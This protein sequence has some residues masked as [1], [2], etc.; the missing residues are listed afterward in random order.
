MANPSYLPRTFQANTD[1]LFDRVIRPVLSSLPIHAELQSGVTGDLNVFLDRCAAQVDNYTAN[2]AAKAFSLT[3]A[4]LFERQLRIWG[5]EMGVT[6]EG[7]KPGRELFR[8]YLPAC[9]AAGRVDLEAGGLGM[10]IVEMFLVANVYRHGDG[11]S[12]RDLIA[13]APARCN[14]DSSRY[15]DILPPNAEWSE[16]MLVEPT[17]VVRY[18]GACARFW[19]RADRLDFAMKEPTYG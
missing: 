17:D 5:R 7:Q 4:G 18:A 2:E 6:I 8:D 15:V 12:V 3:L 9:A 11:T 14:Y 1:R 10:N 19:G 16:Q 13:V